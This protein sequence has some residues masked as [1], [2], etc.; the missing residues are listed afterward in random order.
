MLLKD[1]TA[2]PQMSK[3][4]ELK[5]NDYL[6]MKEQNPKFRT[7]DPLM[8]GLAISQGKGI[9]WA[10]AAGIYELNPSSITALS[11][12]PWKSFAELERSIDSIP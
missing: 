7:D 1:G 5:F 10:S 3:S 8:D 9:I 4:M 2:I 12:K 6:K 11:T